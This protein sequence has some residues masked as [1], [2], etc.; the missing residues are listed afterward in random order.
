MSSTLFPPSSAPSPSV[1]AVSSGVPTGLKALAQTLPV[2]K[3]PNVTDKEEDSVE[4]QYNGGI[5]NG[6][7]E[8]ATVPAS[9]RIPSVIV[10]VVSMCF[11][12]DNCTT[13]GTDIAAKNCTVN[14][15]S[16][17]PYDTE[18]NYWT[19][20][21]LLFP[22]FTVFGNILVLMSVYK[23]RSLQTV[24]NYFIVSLAVADLLLA[25]FVMPFAVYY[26]LCGYWGLGP[27]V[28]DVYVAMDVVCSTS[29]IFN[30]VAISI[31]RYIA[32]TQPIA[33]SQ[34]KNNRR[35]VFTIAIIWV[36]STAI[37]I[38]LFF[39]NQWNASKRS[40][41]PEPECAF[42]NADFIIYSSISSFYIPCIAMIYL[43]CRIFKALKERARKKKP[44][45]SEIKAGSVIENVTQTRMLETAL[46]SE[47]SHAAPAPAKGPP[48]PL[49]EE[50]R[51]TN[52]TSN[53]QDEDEDDVDEAGVVLTGAENCHI[54]KN[55]R[56]EELNLGTV[57]EEESMERGGAT[58]AVQSTRNG[59][60]EVVRG[61]EG[62]GAVQPDPSPRKAL[63]V[64]QKKVKI[65]SK[66]NGAA[67]GRALEG[68]ELMEK[69]DKKASSAR[70]TI[71][72]VNKASKKKREKS[73]AKKERKATKTLAI[74]LGAFLVCWVP[75]F[76]CNIVDAISKK[77]NIKSLE[78]SVT[79][80]WL[81]TWIGYMN[82]FLNPVIY[83][84]FN[85][86]FRKAFK[87][88]LVCQS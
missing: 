8:L 66:R 78:P 20:L 70:F 59:A 65:Q 64:K 15:T 60:A 28:C 46:S 34:S 81:T 26:L 57:R 79:L 10:D 33:Y 30:L 85:P 51:N 76:T 18:R 3:V 16:E 5:V 47:A 55:P 88:I 35:I 11:Q 27:F 53:S 80:F 19:L 73:S 31:D 63:L 24:T 83:T 25:S 12:Y 84:I 6:N 1:G 48:A 69:K 77:T 67:G 23:E 44:K 39:V 38:P 37:G 87:K 21:L 41:E 72:K 45:V 58:A 71:Y 82:S 2:L 13:N 56:P 17:D 54:I 86:E 4:A 68:G 9:T 42:L 40:A 32:V 62:R 29:S 36:V 50:D 43:Y 61:A 49:I 22:V 74:V 14:C 75:F 52:N 7:E